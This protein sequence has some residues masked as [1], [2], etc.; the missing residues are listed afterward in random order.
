MSD[1]CAAVSVIIPCYQAAETIERAVLS[2]VNQT[3][4]PYE[5][6]LVD[7]HS[8]DDTLERLKQLQQRFGSDWLRVIAL[9]QNGGPSVA[10]NTG[11]EEATQP[12]IAFLDAD[13][14]WHPRK[15]E[16]QYKWMRSH[17][18][19]ALTGHPCVWLKPQ[20]RIPS[21]PQ[22]YRAWQVNPWQ[23]LLSNQFSTPTVM[24]R[25][26][27]PYRFTLAKHHSEDYLLWLQIALNGLP[28]WRIEMPLAYLYKAPVGAGGL[29]KDL[30]IMRRGELD[31]YYQLHKQG[32]LNFIQLI[33]LSLVSLVKHIIRLFKTLDLTF[34]LLN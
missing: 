9:S 6:I 27:A 12:Y 2:V 16:M 7:D 15:L 13:D 23:L 14:A 26:D 28:V 8:E 30:W 25:Q 18:N 5:L 17:P 10:R 24:L 33:I 3:V 32:L 22:K 4:M 29:S 21:L 11:W 1:Q 34:K 31:T 19:V 20:A